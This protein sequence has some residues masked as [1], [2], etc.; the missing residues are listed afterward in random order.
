MNKHFDVV[1]VGGGPGGYVAAIR[2]A[3]LGL[4]T[5]CVDAWCDDSGQASLGG[6]CLNVGCIPSKALIE[7]SEWYHRARHEMGAH[8][9]K[10]E[11]V[12]LDLKALLQRKEQVVKALTQGVHAL[13]MANKVSFFHGRG[14]LLDGKRIAVSP[15]GKG[16]KA[17]ELTADNVI[18]AT[19][20][21]PAE[22]EQLP[23][24]SKHIVDSTAA[25]AFD[26][27]PKKLGIIGAGVIAL[28]LGSVWR[29]LGSEVVLLK[30][31]PGLLPAADPHI[32]GEALRCFREQGL[33]FI[34]GARIQGAEI[35]RNKVL[36]SYQDDDGEHSLRL[37]KLI[38]AVGRRPNS[39]GLWD[40]AVGLRRDE[41]GFIEVDA[42]CRTGV[43]GVYA[44][45]DVVRGPMLAHKASEEGVMVAEL[46]AGESVLPVDLDT[47]PA[48]IY[49]DP[50]IA[51][52]GATENALKQ[53]GRAYKVG[54]F[55]FA[56][57]GRARA[58]GRSEGHVRVLADAATDR[59]LGVHIIGPQASELIACAK[60]AMD[61][62]ASSEDVAMTMFAHPTLSEALHEAALSVDQ[63]AIHVVQAGKKA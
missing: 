2:C 41:R 60:L 24:D 56:A 46:I 1:V 21:S 40:E 31:R 30:S 11:G 22:L 15:L 25:L 37:D 12:S 9:I 34:M 54:S 28:E 50:E 59:V 39:E 16:E 19:G 8:G 17:F 63:R 52:V 18:L 48:V 13:F 36:L 23:F 43:D 58:L 51:W 3:Q 42:Y 47:V 14:K 62:G 49:T 38:V 20:S 32:A 7:S 6:T 57:N 29:R 44:I 55:P 5:A 45:G 26:K 10:L 35:K 27:V 61:F 33:Q 53:A 4:A